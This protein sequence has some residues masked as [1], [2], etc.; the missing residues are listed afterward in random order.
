MMASAARWRAHLRL[1]PSLF[2]AALAA[3][4][5]IL[6]VIEFSA[7]DTSS[8]A[9]SRAVAAALLMT[10]ALAWRRRWPLLVFFLVVAGAVVVVSHTPFTGFTTVMIAAYSVGAYTRYRLLSLLLLTATAVA[11]VI[12][13][14]GGL[15][16]LP[17][18]SGP[19]IVL[20]PLWLVGNAISTWRVRAS[21]F[22]DKA[23]RLEREQEQVRL[24][25]IAEEQA[26][27]A[28]ELHDVVAHSV[29]VMVVQAGAARHVLSSSPDKA[30]EALLAVE[31]S[32]R[33]AMAELRRLLGMLQPGDDGAGLAPQPGLEQVSA[34]LRRV[35]AAG[36]PVE[37]HVEGRPYPLPPG[38]NLAA[39]RVVQEGLTN[40]LKYAGQA[41]TIV[42][43]DYRDEELK[44]EVLD[45]GADVP[46]HVGGEM[47]RGL[48]GMRER[49][50]LYGGRLEAGPRLERGYAVRAWLPRWDTCP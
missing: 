35:R 9:P 23:A 3:V 29:S 18:W 31:A 20:L 5:S 14:G 45:E 25:A 39:Y 27:I 6:I 42:V 30:G 34:L 46:A 32:G 36:L 17:Q 44:I 33:E 22:E 15:P 40:A 2:D 41:R 43:L 1:P 11:V 4:L 13:F 16:P 12:E 10:V 28:R 7:S 21:A 24:A 50:A 49:V 26:R 38:V 8:S 48:V 37:M 19:F 47:G